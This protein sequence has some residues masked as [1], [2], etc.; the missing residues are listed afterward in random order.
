MRLPLFPL[1]LVLYPSQIVPLRIDEPGLREVTGKCISMGEPVGVL[2][3]QDGKLSEV[4]CT[5]RISRVLQRYSDGRIDILITGEQRFRIL[6]LHDE[7][8]YLTAEI[9]FLQD[10]QGMPR[11]TARERVIA[12]HMRLMEIAGRTIRPSAYEVQESVSFVIARSAGLT[13]DQR[14]AVLEMSSEQARIDFLVD[15][16]EEFIPRVEKAQ[17]LRATIQSNGHLD[18]EEI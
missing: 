14:Q 17:A 3:K 7:E 4:G 12:Q 13:L 2:C 9:M 10:R 6:I 5:A 18:F 16:F 11:P 15:H 8:Q 1:S